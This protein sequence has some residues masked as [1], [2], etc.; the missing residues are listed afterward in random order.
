MMVRRFMA[1]W[2]K[3]PVII[4]FFFIPLVIALYLAAIIKNKFTKGE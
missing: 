3:L 1:W 2:E 4:G